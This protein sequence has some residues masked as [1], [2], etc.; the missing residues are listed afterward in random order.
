M[1]RKP[2]VKVD[3]K[4]WS[5]ATNEIAFWDVMKDFEALSPTLNASIQFLPG[6]GDWWTIKG[7]RGAVKKAMNY[8]LDEGY[9]TEEVYNEAL[10]DLEPYVFSL[11]D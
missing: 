3:L 2:D 4:T 11:L 9:I 6:M 5:G 1:S 7:P 8:L 10:P